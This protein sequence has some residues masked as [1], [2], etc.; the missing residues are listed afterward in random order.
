[1][2]ADSEA[3]SLLTGDAIFSALPRD[4]LRELAASARIERVERPRIL[5]PAGRPLGWLRL[6][7][8]G[9]VEIIARHAAGEEVSLA[10]IGAGQWVTWA[11]C[12]S[13][14]STPYDFWSSGRARYLALPTQKVRAV[15]AAHPDLYPRIVLDMAQRIRH[16]MEWTGESVLLAPEQ[17]MAKLIVLKAREHGLPA[18]GGTLPLTQARLARLARCS[19]QSA[20]KLLGAL[21]SRGLIAIEYGRVVVR[22]LKALR[23]F[24]VADPGR[25]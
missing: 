5:Q 2:T 11:G 23:A 4:A 13:T 8:A 1:M 12:L 22:D 19:R 7:L 15:C 25:A 14:D 6:V 16:L 21:E 9:H 3:L 17:R 24:V 10:D 18:A 20:N